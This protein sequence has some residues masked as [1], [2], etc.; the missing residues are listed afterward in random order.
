MAHARLSPSSA[1]RWMTCPGSVAAC[2]GLED[3]GSDYAAEGTAAH[4]MAEKILTGTPGGSLIG[5]LAENGVPFTAEMLKGVRKYTD[6]ILDLVTAIDG[7]LHVEQKLDISTWTLEEDAKG[8]ADAVILA[9]N[10]LIV[11]DLKFG[12]GVVVDADENKQL[13]I[14]ALAALLAF[15][16]THTRDI[17]QVRL[18]ISQPNLNAWCEWTCS[19]E[20]LRAFGEEVRLAAIAVDRPDAPRRPSEKACKFCRAKGS[21]PALAAQVAKTIYEGSEADIDSFEDLTNAGIPKPCGFSSVEY[22]ANAMKH[23]KMIESWAKGV[24]AEVERRLFAGETVPGYKLVEGRQGNRQWSDAE[25]VETLMKSMR[26]KLDEMYTMSLISPTRAEE[27]YEAGVIGP[28]KWPRIL[29][30]ITRSDGQPSV[31]PESDKREALVLNASADDFDDVS[32]QPETE[33]DPGSEFL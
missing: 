25:E 16:F 23:L 9:G 13:M 26:L 22:L 31:A 32:D 29:K 28:R 15:E 17:T 6:T 5:K 21:C 14:Y 2:E 18:I 10:E 27:L 24:R 12:R 30:L 4:E 1:E 3:S 33:T 11:A 19:A 8:T 7:E 20:Y